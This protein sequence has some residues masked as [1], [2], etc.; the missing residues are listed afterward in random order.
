MSTPTH[1]HPVGP[2]AD[3]QGKPAGIVTRAIAGGIDYVVVGFWAAGVYVGVAALSFLYNPVGWSWPRWSFGAVL[4]LG[5]VSMVTYLTATWATS[6][7]T[8]G[9]QV[10]GSRVV[11]DGGRV[12][13]LRAFVRALVVVAFPI[14]LF[15]S[16]IDTRSRSVQDL[17]TGTAVLYAWRTDIGHR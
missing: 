13:L 3:L 8:L 7:K 5:A 15:W 14:G 10:M 4:I 17:V 9:G 16:A 6:G 11:R 12:P 2:G 1:P